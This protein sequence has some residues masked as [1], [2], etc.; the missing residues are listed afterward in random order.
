MNDIK[1]Q[2]ES[3]ITEKVIAIKHKCSKNRYK[4]HNKVNKKE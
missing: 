2:Y 3:F 4:L 1:Q